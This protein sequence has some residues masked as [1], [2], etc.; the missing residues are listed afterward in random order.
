[1]IHP[2][3]PAGRTATMVRHE[4]LDAIGT[5]VRAAKLLAAVA[6]GLGWL[7]HQPWCH[8]KTIWTP[9]G[10]GDL[11][12]KHILHIQTWGFMNWDLTNFIWE[13]TVQGLAN[14]IHS[15]PG[16]LKLYNKRSVLA[17]TVDVCRIFH[18]TNK[19]FQRDLQCAPSFRSFLSP[20]FSTDIST[21]NPGRTLWDHHWVSCDQNFG[22]CSHMISINGSF[23]AKCNLETISLPVLG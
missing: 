16:W 9:W 18:Q 13:P 3:Q 6:C 23:S 20:I 7:V 1:M 17:S 14:I 22:H 5:Q 11:T 19:W 2:C 4:V 8:R 10:N 15:S 21:F 12:N